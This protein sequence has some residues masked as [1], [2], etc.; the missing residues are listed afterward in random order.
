VPQGDTN[1]LIRWDSSH[2]ADSQVSYGLTAAY[3]QSTTLDPALVGAHQQTLTGLTPATLYHFQVTSRNGA[4]QAA[5]ST[6]LTF[7]TRSSVAPELPR[8]L[9]DTKYQ[10]PTGGTT[11]TVAAGGNLQSTPPIPAT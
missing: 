9:I 5:S 7:T 6:D 2:L 3:G 10:L 11:I 1:V 4:G 8:R